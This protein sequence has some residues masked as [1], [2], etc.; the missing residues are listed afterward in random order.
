MKIRNNNR[1]HN[2][3]NNAFGID[4]VEFM[5]YAASFRWRE[6]EDWFP[7]DPETDQQTLLEIRAL[8]TQDETVSLFGTCGSHP[9]F[10]VMERERVEAMGSPEAIAQRLRITRKA[11]VALLKLAK[12]SQRAQDRKDRERMAKRELWLKWLKDNSHDNELISLDGNFQEPNPELVKALAKARRKAV[13]EKTAID[14][15]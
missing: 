15:L 1:R 8:P 9:D 13:R 5:S 12:K 4:C 11:A 7:P 6:V 10:I 3:T 2:T 14:S